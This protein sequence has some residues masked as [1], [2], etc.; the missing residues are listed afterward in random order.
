MRPPCCYFTFS[1]KHILNQICCFKISVIQHFVMQFNSSLSF[2]MPIILCLNLGFL[3]HWKSQSS[4]KTSTEYQRR[5]SK[6]QQT[7]VHKVVCQ[8]ENRGKKNSVS[9]V[10]QEYICDPSILLAHISMFYGAKQLK[11]KLTLHL[12]LVPKLK[13]YPNS[14]PHTF[15]CQSA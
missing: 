5:A 15:P 7:A 4:Y 2:H 9:N 11:V 3:L 12:Q 13:W 14:T 8:M 1:K 10:C 6:Y